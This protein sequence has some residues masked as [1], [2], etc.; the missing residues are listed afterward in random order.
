MSE[1]VCTT[2]HPSAAARWV[3]GWWLFSVRF[4]AS[5]SCL[6]GKNHFGA[7]SAAEPG[8]LFPLL[9]LPLAAFPK[10]LHLNVPLV[11]PWL[12]FP[13]HSMQTVQCNSATATCYTRVPQPA[14]RV[15]NMAGRSNGTVW[16]TSIRCFL[17]K[18]IAYWYCGKPNRHR[19]WG[20]SSECASGHTRHWR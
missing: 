5:S 15:W 18:S 2:T 10:V 17:I 1:L 8:P 13:I 7:E 6:P 19:M 16:H 14:L 4:A 9:V 12:F 20:W 11:W 3:F